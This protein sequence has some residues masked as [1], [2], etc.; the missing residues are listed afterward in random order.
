MAG[1]V[2]NGDAWAVGA[3][4]VRSRPRQADRTEM[5]DSKVDCSDRDSGPRSATAITGASPQK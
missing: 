2:T 1:I 3:C 4:G 5:T